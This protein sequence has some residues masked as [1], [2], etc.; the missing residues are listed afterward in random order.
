MADGYLETLLRYLAI[1][2][3]DR[4]TGFA[5]GDDVTGLVQP[6]GATE[7]PIEHAGGMSLEREIERAIEEYLNRGDELVFG[8]PINMDGSEGVR[9]KRVR[10]MADR[11]ASRT[12]RRVHFQDERLTTAD[13][14]WQMARTGMTHGQKKTRRD[15]IAAATILRD[16]LTA[17]HNP[18][19][20]FSDDDEGDT[21]DD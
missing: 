17:L 18:A 5:V 4:R 20:P 14:D 2:L 1:D 8:L 3:G 19:E 6:A 11:V 13:A 9:A 12:G 10:A 16:F 15:A 7:T 21:N